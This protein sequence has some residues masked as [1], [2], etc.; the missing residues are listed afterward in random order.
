MDRRALVFWYNVIVFAVAEKTAD[1]CFKGGL[2]VVF[3]QMKCLKAALFTEY[4]KKCN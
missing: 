2:L 1:K 3:S 4:S